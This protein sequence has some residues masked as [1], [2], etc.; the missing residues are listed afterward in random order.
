MSGYY[1]NAFTW[2]DEAEARLKALAP[3]LSAGQIAGALSREFG[4]SISRNAFIGKLRRLG[5]S[6]SKERP[7]SSAGYVERAR[8]PAAADDDDVAGRIRDLAAA[9]MPR[10][11]ICREVGVSY[12]KVVA[13]LGSLSSGEIEV[14]RARPV[15]ADRNQIGAAPIPP[16]Q[17]VV[18]APTQSEAI[19]LETGAVAESR[20]CSIMDLD[21]KTCRWPVGDVRAGGVMYCGAPKDA[22]KS[23]CAAHRACAYNAPVRTG[24]IMA[25]RWNHSGKR[26]AS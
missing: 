25:I 9:D 11:Q 3:N 14:R 6:L 17:A 18:P 8:V 16:P 13:V 20:L 21:W 15:V 2:T 1:A 24:K 22:G 7:P 23:Y 5:T 19:E 4:A 12:R 26:R 10:R